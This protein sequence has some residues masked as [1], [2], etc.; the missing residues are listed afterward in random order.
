M[1]SSRLP[2]YSSTSPMFF[3]RSAIISLMV[4]RTVCSLI[5]SQLAL[6]VSTMSYQVNPGKASSA[7]QIP[8]VPPSL[9][10]SNPILFI[11]FYSFSSNFSIL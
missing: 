9:S 2:P 6:T 5:F 10:S 8:P 4:L 3:V 7:K 11:P 1:I